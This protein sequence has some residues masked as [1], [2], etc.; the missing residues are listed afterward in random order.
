MYTKWGDILLIHFA[1]KERGS[2]RSQ[3]FS[4]LYIKQVVELISKGRSPLPLKFVTTFFFFFFFFAIQW[5]ST[6]LLY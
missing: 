6:C 3:D 2:A 4:S 5:L 1:D